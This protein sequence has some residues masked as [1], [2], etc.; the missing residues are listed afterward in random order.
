MK[1]LG[2]VMIDLETM[3]NCSLSS[4]LSI[5]AVE[6][7]I[8]TGETGKEFYKRIH[9]QSCLDLGLKVQ[10]ETIYWWLQQN[11]NARLEVCK[12]GDVL[13]KVLMDLNN[14]F[15]ELG[16]F[17]LW[18]NGARFDIGILEDAYVACQ[19]KSIWNFRNERDVRTLVSFLPKIKEHYPFEG[20]QH[21]PIHDCKHQIAYCSDI[22]QN[23][24][25]NTDKL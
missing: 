24:N 9:L 14:Y 25:I 15:S 22:W 5:G 10:A 20:I 2:H 19:I 16:D 6:F 11:E 18:G 12:G 8:N 17:Q 3:G 7:D 13:P 23:L 4:I 1:N 21:N